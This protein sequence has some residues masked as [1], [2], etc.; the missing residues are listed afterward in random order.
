[1]RYSLNVSDVVH[2]DGLNVRMWYATSPICDSI[3]AEVSVRCNWSNNCH[4]FFIIWI[5][6]AYN[7]IFPDHMPYPDI[8]WYNFPAGF[9]YINN[10][11][12]VNIRKQPF[13]R[14]CESFIIRFVL[15]A[16][17]GMTF[18]RCYLPNLGSHWLSRSTLICIN[19]LN[20]VK[21][22]IKLWFS[23]FRTQRSGRDRLDFKRPLYIL[24]WSISLSLGSF[25]WMNSILS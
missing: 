21:T 17:F 1:M 14:S 3:T 23:I 16:S 12:L 8:T 20:L 4:L 11:V 6:I 15:R 24:I 2:P 18:S 19:S 22:Y 5:N 25:Q 13:H 10:V 7:M 9:I